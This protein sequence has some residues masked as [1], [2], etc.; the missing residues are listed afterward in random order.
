M[1]VEKRCEAKIDKLKHGMNALI[2]E[3]DNLKIELSKKEELL[4]NSK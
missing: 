2:K 4:K 1:T 3:I